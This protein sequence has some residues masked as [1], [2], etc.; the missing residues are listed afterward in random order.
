M[1]KTVFNGDPK[2]IPENAQKTLQGAFEG[3]KISMEITIDQYIYKAVAVPLSDLRN[4]INEVLVVMHNIT[5]SKRLE[6][7]LYRTIDQEKKLN[8]LKSRFVSMASHE[9]RTPLST[10][11]SSLFLMESYTG[12][13]YE[14]KKHIHIKRIKRTVNA[15][16]E[17][18]NDFLRLGK[19]EEGN[20][21]M[22]LSETDIQEETK[23]TLSDL[24][25][26]ARPGQTIRYEHSGCPFKL[27]IDKVILRSI[28]T[29]LLSNAIKYSHEG[30]EIFLSTYLSQHELI[31]TITDQGIGIAPEETEHIF[32][33]FFRALNASNIEGTGLGLHI[34]KKY[35][36]LMNGTIDFS[37][38]KDGTTFTIK[39][40][41][42]LTRDKKRLILT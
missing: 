5:E 35:V 22:I 39:I 23:E 33:R 34:V 36:E 25:S 11:L 2:L 14:E 31:I 26:V 15:L 9:F 27:F 38:G 7:S 18:L 41:L 29:N 10:I 19:L 3:K 28:L 12:A 40:P 16:T 8:D 32:Q 37:S 21:E 1:G 13:L 42:L 20:I 30:G 4:A 6:E 24:Q 17:T